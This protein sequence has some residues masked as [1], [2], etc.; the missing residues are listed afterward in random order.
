MGDSINEL[1]QRVANELASVLPARWGIYSTEVT[2][3]GGMAA[4]PRASACVVRALVG[5]TPHL[6]RE[7]AG[8]GEDLSTAI[9][10]LHNRA[11]EISPPAVP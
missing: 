5:P 1:T 6:V 2:L 8:V 9:V 7:V 3:R 11:R 4:Q 10:D